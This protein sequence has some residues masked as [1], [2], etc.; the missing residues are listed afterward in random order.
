MRKLVTET[1]TE[2]LEELLGENVT[3]FCLN[4]FYHGKLKAYDDRD[5]I[6]E[7]PSII[8]ETGKFS[9]KDFKDI[10]SLCTKEWTINR[11]CVESFGV[12]DGKK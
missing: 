3:I 7:N 2:R 5:I 6:L 4:Y 8:Y 12:L 10:Q 11:G 1:Q 9:D